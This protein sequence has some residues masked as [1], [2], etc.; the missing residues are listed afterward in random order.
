MRIVKALAVA[1]LF[2]LFG[3][4]L[5]HAND[6]NDNDLA[7]AIKSRDIATIRTIA[8][9]ADMKKLPSSGWKESK[10]ALEALEKK[11]ELGSQDGHFLL[12]IY[13]VLPNEGD[14]DDRR[15]LAEL[16]EVN[17]NRP[18]YTVVYMS[19]LELVEKVDDALYDKIDENNVG[20]I[21]GT[22][23]EHCAAFKNGNYYMAIPEVINGLY[24]IR[25]K[26]QKD[27]D[28]KR[29]QIQRYLRDDDDYDVDDEQQELAFIERTIAMLD[30]EIAKI[31][32]I[33]RDK[34]APEE[35][36]S[37]LF[38]RYTVSVLGCAGVATIAW[39]LYQN[40]WKKKKKDKSGSDDNALV[41]NT[42]HAKQAK[43]VQVTA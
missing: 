16:V 35:S 19:S 33:Y 13:N 29:E 28:E 14:K 39:W 8:Q 2:S 22:V 12:S 18:G 15:K 40:Y 24:V 17:T 37:I 41:K 10:N 9:E 20:E 26:E 3:N 31:E 25:N 38:N 1:V 6:Y 4:T 34:T 42:K 23:R 27:A 30:E 11:V 36:G 21:F 5:V 43:R 7:S 32:A